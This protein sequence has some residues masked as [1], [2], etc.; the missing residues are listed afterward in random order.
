[1]KD[2]CFSS[3]S[4]FDA[5]RLVRH[6]SEF[7]FFIEGECIL[8]VN[9][10]RYVTLLCEFGLN[11]D[12]Q[13][14]SLVFGLAR[15]RY[16]S[17]GSMPENIFLDTSFQVNLTIWSLN[18]SESNYFLWSY[19]KVYIEKLLIHRAVWNNDW[20]RIAA[21]CITLFSKRKWSSFICFVHLKYVTKFVKK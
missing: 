12:S 11:W 19:L 21:I 18:V 17:I 2:P 1:M 4:L 7:T 15:M 20:T 14:T 16:I 5:E 13:L 9:S 8:A 3:E 6:I 10:Q